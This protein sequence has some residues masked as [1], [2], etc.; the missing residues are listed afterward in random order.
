MYQTFVCTTIGVFWEEHDDLAKKTQVLL[1]DTD[2]QRGVFIQVYKGE[3]HHDCR[4][5]HLLSR[6]NI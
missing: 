2:N 4:R 5:K 6:E 1:S 3:S